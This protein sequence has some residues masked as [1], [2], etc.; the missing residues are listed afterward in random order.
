MATLESRLQ[1]FI[2]A[3]GADIGSILDGVFM[4]DLTIDQDRSDASPTPRWRTFFTGTF[5]SSVENIAEHYINGTLA[6]YLNEWG[7]VRG[8]SPYSG[9]GDPLFR[10]IHTSTDGVTGGNA[11]EISDRTGTPLTVRGHNWVTG[12][13]IRN[14]YS[15]TE[16]YTW[17]WGDADPTSGGSVALPPN[18][19]WTI[20]LPT[21]ETRPTWVPAGSTVKRY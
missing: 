15:V 7:A 16:T 11:Y 21:A 2:A 9:A 10:A 8:T 13:L 14:G 6:A 20:I 1:D 12:K 5:A 3:V 18:T 19:H 17:T 4:A